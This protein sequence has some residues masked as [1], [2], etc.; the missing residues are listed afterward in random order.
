[1]AIVDEGW[2]GL[3]FSTPD[4]K[5]T[6]A[7]NLDMKY[8]KVFSTPEG[9][10][11]LNDLLNRTV[12]RPTWYPELPSSYGYVREGQNMIVREITKRIN[13]ATTKQ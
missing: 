13:R 2:D 4:E 7:I 6:D 5:D 11:V 10:E 3:D 1:M 8:A 9:L 12:E